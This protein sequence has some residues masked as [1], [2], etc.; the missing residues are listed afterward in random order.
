VYIET[1]I[2]SYLAARPSRDLVRA[3]HQQLTYEWW[4]A[5]RED[6]DLYISQFVLDEAGA[7]DPE[8]ARKRLGLLNEVSQLPVTE[9]SLLLAERLVREGVLPEK[10]ATDALHLAVATVH[11]MD[12][13]LTWNCR[14]LANAAILGAVG[15]LVRAEDFE[16]PVVCTPE[17]L[18]G[19][20][21]E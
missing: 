1:T 13:L 14:H 8:F 7:G 5:R 21:G 15:R 3:A 6:F 10:A 2:P 19:E 20:T 12:I 18:M 16:M 4:D 9:P 11:Q 17:E